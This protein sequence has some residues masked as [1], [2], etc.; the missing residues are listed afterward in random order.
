MDHGEINYVKKYM[1]LSGHVDEHADVTMQYGAHRPMEAVHGYTGSHWTPLSGENI[2]T[3]LPRRPP[4]S[5]IS[6]Q[7]MELWHCEIAVSK[8]AFKPP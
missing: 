4:W 3:V 5:S 1:Y 2:C 8:L 6:A 7:K